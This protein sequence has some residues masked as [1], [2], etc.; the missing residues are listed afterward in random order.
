MAEPRYV[1]GQAVV[2]GVMMRGTSTWA[3]AVRRPDGEIEVDVREVPCVGREVPRRPGRARR[4]RTRRIARPR[5][6]RAHVVGERAD[7]RR[8]AGLRAHD[9]LDAR[10]RGGVL[11]RDLHP[12]PGARGQGPLAPVPRVVPGRRGHRAA[13]TVHRLPA[14]RRAPEGH[15]AR[16]PVPR[17]RAQGHRRVRE[18]RRAHA[19]DRAAVLDRARALRNQLPADRDGRRGVRVLA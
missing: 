4:R 5:L 2:E 9:G 12:H 14:R 3:I 8:G 15:Q 6:P 11:Q 13:R 1:G 19:R 7:A 17:R 10:G 16:V 18:R